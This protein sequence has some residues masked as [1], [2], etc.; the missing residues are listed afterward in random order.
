MH[1]LQ[2]ELHELSRTDDAIFNFLRESTLDGM[3]YWDLEKPENEWMSPEFWRLFGYDPDKMP[4]KADAW[5]DIIHPDDLTVAIENF[6][7]HLADPTHP[8]DQVVRYRHKDTGKDVTVRCRGIAIRDTNGKPVRM[9]GAHTDLTELKQ[10]EDRLRTANM[11]LTA[12]RNLSDTASRAKTAFLENMSHE[13]RTP[14][15]GVVGMTEALLQTKLEPNQLRMAKVID[16]SARSLLV[17]L[18]DIL[19]FS[20]IE[21]G[22]ISMEFSNFKPRVLVGEV[23]D[24]FEQSASEKQIELNFTASTG[25]N[26]LQ[27]GSPRAV[28]QVLTNLISNALKFTP[29]A[30]RVV[31]T[32][33]VLEEYQGRFLEISVRDTGPGIPQDKAETIFNRFFQLDEKNDTVKGTGLGLAIAR[34]LC[35]L[36]GGSLKLSTPEDGV[37]SCFS[38]RFRFGEANSG[39]A[40]PDPN[41]QRELAAPAEELRLLVAEDNELNRL[42]I[43]A[44]LARDT[45]TLEFAVN[46]EDALAR[47]KKSDFDAAL[48]DIRM[49]VMDGITFASALRTHERDAN[50]PSLPLVACSANVL[51]YQVKEYLSAGFGHH[52]PKPITLEALN[53][54]LDWITQQVRSKAA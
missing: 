40:V 8:Y 9:L 15:N 41:A 20:R 19:D 17:L 3:W 7:K 37:G 1:Y 42:V 46:G 24:L 47:A 5:Q 21:A 45:I 22:K 28:R 33:R 34:R 11:E 49:P 29:E 26:F 31:I 52:L 35:E 50:L 16:T 36:H 39:M 14:M 51:P 23:I 18:N 43:E 53:E 13:I 27:I 4:H 10:A 48:V 44:M 38:A 54:T 12:S 30:G 2:A 32:T 6:E 25:S